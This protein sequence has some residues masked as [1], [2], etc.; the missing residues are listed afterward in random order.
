[1]GFRNILLSVSK[2]A[3]TMARWTFSFKTMQLPR[4]LLFTAHGATSFSSD[5]MLAA[6]VSRCGVVHTFCNLR[7]ILRALAY[8]NLWKTP[9]RSSTWGKRFGVFLWV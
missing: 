5:R 7:R 1:M 6:Q 4:I 3:A 8:V 2:A 9:N